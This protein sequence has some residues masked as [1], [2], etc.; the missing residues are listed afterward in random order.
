MLTELLLRC[1]PPSQ[2][3]LARQLAFQIKN[4]QFRRAFACNCFVKSHD[5]RLAHCCNCYLAAV[6]IPSVICVFVES[7]FGVLCSVR[8]CAFEFVLDRRAY[9]LRRCQQ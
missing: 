1:G 7:S 3:R 8:M 6:G 2:H 4:E 5:F 9:G